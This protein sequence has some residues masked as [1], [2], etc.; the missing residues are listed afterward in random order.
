[1][2]LGIALPIGNAESERVFS[3]L[4]RVFSKER[5]SLSNDTMLD[6]LR[7]RCDTNYNTQRYERAI[8]LFLSEHPSGKVREHHRRLDGHRPAKRPRKQKS[9]STKSF[10]QALD[11]AVQSSA[12]SSSD[13]EEE[14][15][16]Q[17]RREI[18]LEEISDDEFL[19]SPSES[20]DDEII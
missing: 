20:S 4:W 8:E 17:P 16:E 9:V 6:I 1:M 14:S 12:S 2:E 7:L 5:Q 15:T 19:W 13:E 10:R 18:T 11:E 3:F